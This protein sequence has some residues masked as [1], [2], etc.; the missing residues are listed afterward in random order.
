MSQRELIFNLLLLTFESLPEDNNKVTL[1]EGLFGVG[2]LRSTQPW[3]TLMSIPMHLPL[4]FV[5]L[6]V[7]NYSA[8][9]TFEISPALSRRLA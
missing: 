3:F 2:M 7:E 9:F 5:T 6:N 4:V 8:S 1:A